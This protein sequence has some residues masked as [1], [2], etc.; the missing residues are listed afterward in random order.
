MS[1][2]SAA[3]VNGVLTVPR[4]PIVTDTAP[5]KFSAKN[6]ADDRLVTAAYTFKL[7]SREERSMIYQSL[8]GQAGG[9]TQ[10]VD[11]GTKL[12]LEI[13]VRAVPDDL[14]VRVPQ[15]RGYHYA[16]AGNKIFLVSPLTRVVVGVFSDRN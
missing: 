2:H 14:I 11:I 12:S 6:A 15:T 9:S 13:E 1:Q 7:L 8:R 16:V 5:A 4:A 10:K 3:L